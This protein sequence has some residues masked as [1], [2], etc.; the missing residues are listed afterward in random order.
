MLYNPPAG[1]VGALLA[2]LLGKQ[3]GRQIEEDLDRLKQVIEGVSTQP[4]HGRDR[5]QDASEASFPASDAP[6]FNH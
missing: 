6:A 2:S 5:V 1:T 3:P 4:D